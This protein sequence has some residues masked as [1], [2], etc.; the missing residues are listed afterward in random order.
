MRYN[1][2]IVVKVTYATD[3]KG[4]EIIS[5]TKG[6]EIISN[7][8]CDEMIHALNESGFLDYESVEVTKVTMSGRRSQ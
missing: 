4:E 1:A 7:E 6:E 8:I 5:D 2:E 3:T